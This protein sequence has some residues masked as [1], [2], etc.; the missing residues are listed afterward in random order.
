MLD[1]ISQKDLEDIAPTLK[2]RDKTILATVRKC[3]YLTTG[4]VQRLHFTDAATA[5]AAIRSANRN[6]DKLRGFGL[7]NALSRR[8]G[9]VRAGSTSL[10]WY[11]TD[12]GE[13]MLRLE[14]YD[15]RPRK[16]FFEPSPYFLAHTLAVSECYV[17][18]FELCNGGDLKLVE[19]KIEPSCW[20]PHNY[21]GA[22]T[23]LK[24]DLFAVTSSGK[25][26]DRYFFE[27]D[28]NT[29]TPAVILEKCHRY[30]RYYQSG[31]EQ[32]QYGVFPLT[33]WIVPDTA[34]K[35]SFTAHIRAEFQK[36]PRLF[37]VITPDELE[38][39][40]RQGVEGRDLC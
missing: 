38:K 9:G 8:I 29:E 14:N 21:K 20:R 5:T 25:Y 39:L 28:L 4:Q 35:D 26:E 22:I 2:E 23:T 10:I 6:L 1:R 13:R 30:H 32:K 19:A 17:Q 12:A 34:R 31:L 18:L 40:I 11:L 37:I 24:P 3:R 16:R 15:A 36:L 27:I 33:V 7:V